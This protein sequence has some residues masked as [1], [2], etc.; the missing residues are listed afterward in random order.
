MFA[1]AERRLH[2]ALRRVCVLIALYDLPDGLEV[3][4]TG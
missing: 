1:H 4:R 2:E 3:R